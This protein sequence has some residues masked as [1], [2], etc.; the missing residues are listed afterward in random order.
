MKTMNE[1]PEQ[2]AIDQEELKFLYQIKKELD[3]NSSK[4]AVKLVASV[5]QA[6]RQTLDLAQANALLNKLPD[7]L[8]LTFAA[9]WKQNETNADVNHLDELVGLVME[10]DQKQRNGLFRNEVQTLTVVVLTL[11]KLQKLI[12]I[13]NFEGLSPALRQELKGLPSSAAA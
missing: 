11:K 7:F 9:N 3:L 2:I 1:S 5:L 6:L 10:R 12:D 8:K 13:E 4:D